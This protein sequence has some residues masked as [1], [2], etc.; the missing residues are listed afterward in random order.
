M[1]LFGIVRNFL[2]KTKIVFISIKPSP[3]RKE[4]MEEM[5]K[6]NLAIREFLGKQDNADF[7]DVFNPMLDKDGLPKA[8]LFVEDNVHLNEKG[9]KLWRKLLKPYLE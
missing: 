7:V 9:Y 3:A 8:D 6:A 4:K 2:P 1:T 5:N